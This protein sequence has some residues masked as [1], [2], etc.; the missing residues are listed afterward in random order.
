[1]DATFLR[2]FL[3]LPCL[4]AMAAEQFVTPTSIRDFH[5]PDGY[6]ILVR[7]DNCLS[8]HGFKKFNS[9]LSFRTFTTMMRN[10]PTGIRSLKFHDQL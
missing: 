2:L 4:S 7:M 3:L 9:S 10:T 6:E 8:L 1:M 5:L